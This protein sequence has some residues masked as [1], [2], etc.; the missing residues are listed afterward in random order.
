MRHRLLRN[1]LPEMILPIASNRISSRIQSSRIKPTG[2]DDAC[3]TQLLRFWMDVRE[4][5]TAMFAPN[6]VI[7]RGWLVPRFIGVSPL[8]TRLENSF[9][10]V[11]FFRDAH[12]RYFWPTNSKRIGIEIFVKRSFAYTISTREFLR[13]IYIYIT[14]Q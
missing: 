8:I 7:K 10:R 6:T 11:E 4:W 13:I 1:G 12:P 14:V 9:T 5:L 3:L 2:V